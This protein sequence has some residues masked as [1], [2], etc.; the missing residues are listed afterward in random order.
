MQNEKPNF[1]GIALLGLLAFVVWKS[2]AG[3]TPAPP[4]PPAP[5][6]ETVKDESAAA[7]RSFVQSMASNFD[8]L[9]ADTKAGKYKTVIDASASANQLD[10]A[11][12]NSFKRA[13]AKVMEPKLGSGELPADAAQ[14][15]SDIAAGFR[16][17]K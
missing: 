11:A 15:F 2:S 10:L 17:I 9:A 5:V 14:T 3:P 1:R 7:M 8:T 13:M 6:V 16:G 12:R 4:T